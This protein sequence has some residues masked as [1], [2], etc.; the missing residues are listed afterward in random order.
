[1][2]EADPIA[3]EFAFAEVRNRLIHASQ[4]TELTPLARGLLARALEFSVQG[5]F[6]SWGFPV[7]A[8]LQ[9]DSRELEATAATILNFQT[10]HVPGLLQVPEYARRTFATESQAGETEIAA[11]VAARMNRQAIVYTG[12]KNLV[13]IMTESAVRWR[14][15]PESLTRAQIEKIIGV[16]DLENVTIGVLPQAAEADVWHDHGFNI[17]DDRGDAGDPVVH[18]ETLTRGLTITDPADVAAYKHAFA[19]LQQLAVTGPDVQSLLRQI[20]RP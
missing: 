20:V 7:L 1:M 18:V 3:I 15:G 9:E 12:S 16:A 2:T 11:A 19:R 17:L 10:A 5:V 4:E 14:L 6:V 8:R 13:F